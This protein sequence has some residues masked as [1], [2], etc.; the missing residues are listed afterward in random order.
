M[1]WVSAI[2]GRI[3][4]VIAIDGKTLCNSGDTFRDTK[5]I[6]LVNAFAVENQ[7]ILGQLATEAKSNEIT[8]IPEL[9]KLLTIEGSTI[10][11]D[12]MGCQKEI[13][14]HIKLQ[15]GEYVIALKGNQGNLYA[16]IENFFQQAKEVMP[17]ES[18]CD[19]AQRGGKKSRKG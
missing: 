11:I 16:E 9:L 1:N 15:G 6:H 17:I 18:G 8:A 10:T 2:A 14:Q 19:F 3:Q 7:L 13:V 4:G 12:A 5:P